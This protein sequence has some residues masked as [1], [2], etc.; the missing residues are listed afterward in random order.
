MD[1]L[2]ATYKIRLV[3]FDMVFSEP[4]DSSG[5][6]V[7]ERLAAG[8][9][10]GNA[11]YRQ[12]LEK[13]RGQLDYDRRFAAALEGRNAILGYYF[14]DDARP[15]AAEMLPRSLF[16]LAD[17]PE[18]AWQFQVTRFASAAAFSSS[19][20]HRRLR[21]RKWFRWQSACRRRYRHHARFEQPVAEMPPATQAK[22]LRVL[23]DRRIRPVGS[24][25]EI[26]VDVRV[27]AATNRDLKDDVA[28]Q[29]FRQDLYYRLQVV[30]VSLPPLRDRP[31][32]GRRTC[33]SQT[34]R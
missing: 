7:L 2:F 12:A 13:V 25:Q 8:E 11:D 33:P 31:E 3:G 34:C 23:E 24:E 26:P 21:H 27:I 9:L 32:A 22:L 17:F 16:P 28:N 15:L 30:E 19:T 5:M 14:A 1:Q 4:D 18:L 6:A 29:R 20:T 10:K